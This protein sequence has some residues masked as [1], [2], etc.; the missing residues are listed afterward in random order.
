MRRRRTARVAAAAMGSGRRRGERGD[1]PAMRSVGVLA[2]VSPHPSR[3]AAAAL[4]HPATTRLHEC[5]AHRS[6]HGTLAISSVF[7]SS[8]T[9]DREDA[10]DAYTYRRTVLCRIVLRPALLIWLPSTCY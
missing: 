2:S 1:H 4:Q 9:R 10:H 7:S 5:T 6:A 3:H 8:R